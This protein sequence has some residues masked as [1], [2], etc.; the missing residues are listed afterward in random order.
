M[1]DLMRFRRLQARTTRLVFRNSQFNPALLLLEWLIGDDRE[2][3]FIGVKI[4]RSV[5][6]GDWDADEFDL[7]DHG[8]SNPS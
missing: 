1:N 2:P 6:V 5:L 4:Q 3:R 8:A 7:L